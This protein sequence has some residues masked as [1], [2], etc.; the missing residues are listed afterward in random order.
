MYET[1]DVGDKLSAVSGEKKKA[2]GKKE[3]KILTE[4]RAK[5]KDERNDF[6]E[7]DRFYVLLMPEFF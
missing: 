4:R 3:K 5:R 6:Y 2:S 7:K 1:F